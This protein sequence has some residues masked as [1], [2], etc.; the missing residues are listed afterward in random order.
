MLEEVLRWLRTYPGLETLQVDTVAFQPGS[1]GLYPRGIRQESCREDVLGKRVCQ[2]R[3][4]FLLR[5][6][7]QGREATAKWL[8]DFQDWV[9]RQD[10]R[11]F[12]GEHTCVR[13]E[14]GRLAAVTPSGDTSYEVE[15]HFMYQI[16]QEE[17]PC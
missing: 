8:L 12:F 9:N 13:A 17:E 10:I 4:T 15:I 6:N 16:Y 5:L 3:Q 11:P 14:K 2:Y 1:C 7:G